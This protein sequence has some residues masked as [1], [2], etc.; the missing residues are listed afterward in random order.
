M[1][2]PRVDL[3]IFSFFDSS[4]NPVTAAGESESFRNN[5]FGKMTL[6]ISGDVSGIGLKMEGCVN[7]LSADGQT[8]PD[9]EVLW[10]PLILENLS[11]GTQT[12]SVTAK[13]LYAAD[14]SG[15]QRVRCNL[16]TISGEAI[17]SA[18]FAR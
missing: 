11:D 2:Q 8:L 16:I 12:T 18:V 4:K 5:G 7:I 6:E 1:F 9:D 15:I 13:G 3:Q 17:I 10:T 14:V